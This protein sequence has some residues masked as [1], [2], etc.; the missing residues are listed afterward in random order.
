MILKIKQGLCIFCM[1]LTQHHAITQQL[2]LGLYLGAANYNGDLSENLRSSLNHNHPMVNVQVR[3]DVDP[4]FSL[5]FQA[6]QLTISGDDSKATN[7]QLLK[8]NLNFETRIYEL[9][10]IGQMQIFNLFRLEPMRFSPYLQMGFAYLNFHPRG[11]YN[12]SLVDLQ[13]LGTEGQGMPGYPD[14][15]NLHTTA[16]V[17]GGGLRYHL[18]A[19]L[20]LGLELNLRLSNTDYLDDASGNYVAYHELLR[21]K[22]RTAAELGNKINA[23][24][25][26]QRANPKSNDGY[27]TLGIG[28]HYHFGKNPLFKNSLFRNPVRCPSF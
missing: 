7:P 23:R 2:D 24:T 1:F 25:G 10:L 15:Y 19:H 5:K 6:T 16:Y 21:F 26:Q 14:K 4:V 12:G 13:A 20:S 17:F 27:Q 11:L 28:L 8:R 22:G 9:A 3:L 18:T